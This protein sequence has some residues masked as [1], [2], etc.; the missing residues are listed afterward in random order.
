[1]RFRQIIGHEDIKERF[2]RSVKD[3][4]ISH[5]QLFIGNE[6]NGK[7][8]LAIAYAQYINCTKKQ[9]FEVKEYG[10]S[11]D[12]CGVC[13]SCK[14]YEK[15]IH[16]DLHFVFPVI[17]S[18]KHKEPV[19]DI[20]LKE[21]R[22]FLSKQMFGDLN[23]W[24]D[25]IG[26]DNSQASIFT[27][28]SKEILRKLNLKTY[29]AEYKVMIIW[30]PEKMNVSAANK[31]LKILEEPPP[32]TLFLLISEDEGKILRTI[33]SRTQ[34]TKI[35]KFKDKD[36]LEWLGNNNSNELND[37]ELEFIV[38]L[39]NGNILKAQEQSQKSVMN[40]ENFENFTKLMRLAYA[41]N[42]IELVGWADVV[43]K[44]GR[45]KQKS[46]LEYTLRLVR[47][48]LMLNVVKTN[49]LVYLDKKEADFS[50]KF[51]PFITAPKAAKIYREINL[52]FEHITRNV[53]AK[54]VL[55]DMALQLTI[56]IKSN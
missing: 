13:P 30:L 2:I 35:P 4:R 26:A 56:I 34:M 19:S 32:K 17:N 16:P 6:G 15:L 37:Q 8:A 7:L 38:R 12:S 39:A 54:L 3:S 27:Q 47:E 50:S 43:S 52:A 46:F 9:D 31:L 10:I 44:W 22:E 29:E 5:A 49:E 48:N 1:M 18:A 42:I 14:K 36:I 45:E 28:E 55:L 40:T 11:S 25:Y 24:L 21:W 51:H 23:L 33:L 41:A 20:F 53:S